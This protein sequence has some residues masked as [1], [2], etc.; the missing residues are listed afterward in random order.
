MA[1]YCFSFLQAISSFSYKLL[2]A[3]TVNSEEGYHLEWPDSHTHPHHFHAKAERALLELQVSYL[4]CLKSPIAASPGESGSDVIV[5][6]V[7]QGGQFNIR[8][9]ERCLSMLFDH[10]ATWNASTGQAPSMDL[11]SGYFGLSKAYQ[12]L[13]LR[14]SIDCNIIAASP[15]VC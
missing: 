14:S 2:P 1:Q 8:E 15:K 6:P 7:I 13:V 3:P 11:T 5:F 10:V 9:E 4:K 12:D